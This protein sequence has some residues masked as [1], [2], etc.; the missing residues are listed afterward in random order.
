MRVF[1]LSDIHVDYQENRNWLSGL[2]SVDYLEDT[3]ILAGDVTDE[4]KLLETCFRELSRKFL[5]VLFVPGNHDLWVLRDRTSV[6]MTSIDKYE[7][8]CRVAIENDISMKPLQIDSLSIV[9]LLGWYDFSFASPTLE[10]METWMDFRACVWP[11]HLQAL[12]ITEYLLEKNRAYL[13]TANQTVI[14]FSHFLPRI[15]L[16]PFFIPK[17]YRYV[18]PVLGS[19]LL[20]KQIRILKPDIHVYGHSHVNRHVT[21]EGIQY[22]NNAFG[23]PSE[24]R[25]TNKNLL[26]IYDR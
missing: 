13:Q 24:S 15:D 25:I 14:S 23:T 5:K 1:A 17:S 3:L 4:L 19:V 10:L 21:L 18:Y 16:M 6:S 7:Q 26:C 20:E 22:I 2:S 12:D 9:P 8:V 11:D